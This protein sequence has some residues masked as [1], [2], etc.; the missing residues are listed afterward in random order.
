[1]VVG[2]AGADLLAEEKQ[3]LISC[4]KRSVKVNDWNID[5]HP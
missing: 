3:R 5:G 2:Q 4:V 1:M